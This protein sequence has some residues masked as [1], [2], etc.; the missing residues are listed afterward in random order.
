MMKNNKKILTAQT[1]CDPFSEKCE[2]N[3]GIPTFFSCVPIGKILS[4]RIVTT[5]KVR[6]CHPVFY[7]LVWA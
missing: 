6:T 3:V 5:P 4:K 2:K 1:L 7:E